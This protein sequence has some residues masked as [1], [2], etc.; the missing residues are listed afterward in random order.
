VQYLNYAVAPGFG[1]IL[2][3]TFCYGH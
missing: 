3:Y 2:L 1:Q